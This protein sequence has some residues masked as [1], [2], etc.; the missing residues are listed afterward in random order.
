MSD[1]TLPQTCMA[2]EDQHEVLLRQIQTIREEQAYL[3]DIV[4]G[5]QEQMHGVVHQLQEMETKLASRQLAFAPEV[6]PAP[7]KPQEGS[8]EVIY[9]EKD[10]GESPMK[11]PR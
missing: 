7:S 4:L 6:L 5:M 3:R 1:S 2:I 8:N 10:R 9:R 11:E